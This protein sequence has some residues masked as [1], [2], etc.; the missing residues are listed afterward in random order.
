MEN[1][2]YDPNDDDLI[3]QIN[4]LCIGLNFKGATKDAFLDFLK[5]LEYYSF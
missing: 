1:G 2:H 5:D 3:R 4:K